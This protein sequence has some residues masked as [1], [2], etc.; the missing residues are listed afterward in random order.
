MANCKVGPPQADQVGRD[1]GFLLVLAAGA[2]DDAAGA[3]GAAAAAV[4]AGEGRSAVPG[5]AT[6]VAPRKMM[7][8]DAAA[9]PLVLEARPG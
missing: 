2:A 4:C 9:L 1:E 3:A 6:G 7:E 8:G 5:R